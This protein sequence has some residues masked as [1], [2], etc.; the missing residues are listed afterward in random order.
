MKTTLET[1][2]YRTRDLFYRDILSSAYTMSYNIHRADNIKTDITS[3][4]TLWTLWE[5]ILLVIYRMIRAPILLPWQKIESWRNGTRS[6]ILHPW[7]WCYRS[8]RNCKSSIVRRNEVRLP[9]RRS[10][11]LSGFHLAARIWFQISPASLPIEKQSALIATIGWLK[12]HYPS[13]RIIDPVSN[14]RRSRSPK[15]FLRP[16]ER[17]FGSVGNT[18]APDTLNQTA[19]YIT[20][21]RE[22][23]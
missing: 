8:I 23:A 21:L 19:R 11:K 10:G 14:I 16:E 17:V 18:I 13:F 7:R 1:R 20:R 3:A 5:Y 9:R 15:T 4:F 2:R 12:T 6:R 22:L